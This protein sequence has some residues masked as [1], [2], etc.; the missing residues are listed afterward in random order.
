MRLPLLVVLAALLP[1][2][3]LAN[4]NLNAHPVEANLDGDAEP[5]RLSADGTRKDGISYRRAVLH[6]TCDAEPAKIILTPRHA[7]VP[8]LEARDLDGRASRPEI[9]VE[10]RSGASS[11]AGYI[12]IYRYSV[13]CEAAKQL[14]EYSSNRPRPRPP[15][16][17]WVTN[18]GLSIKNYER[19][20]AARELR[21]LENLAFDDQPAVTAN[22]S[23][24]TYWRYRKGRYVRYRTRVEMPTPIG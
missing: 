3:A 23:R 10:A 12:G 8:V 6:D 9:Y 16:G 15:E 7:S 2:A 13:G 17:T 4:H 22:G 24:T 1:G 14:F 18:F 21:L 11:G 20:S 5:E 19:S